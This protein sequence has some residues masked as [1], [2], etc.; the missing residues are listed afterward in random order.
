MEDFFDEW[1]MDESSMNF[2]E[3][4]TWYSNESRKEA[5]ACIYEEENNQAN[6][7]YAINTIYSLRREEIKKKN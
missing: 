6:Y 1:F 3:F 5:L 2:K 4:G 7:Q